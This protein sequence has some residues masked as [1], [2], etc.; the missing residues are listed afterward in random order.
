MIT[1][2]ISEKGDDG[3]DG[4]TPETA[5]RTI[6]E[7]WKRVQRGDSLAIMNTVKMGEVM[8]DHITV[9]GYPEEPR[10]IIEE[11]TCSSM[12]EQSPSKR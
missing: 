12:D 10:L 11:R 1:W 6:G 4:L 9:H 7:A 3:K 8:K 5:L 2:Y